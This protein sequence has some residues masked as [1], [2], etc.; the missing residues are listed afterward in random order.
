MLAN[1]FHGPQPQQNK[2]FVSRSVKLSLN[3]ISTFLPDCISIVRPQ[4]ALILVI[5][6]F[7]QKLTVSRDDSSYKKYGNKT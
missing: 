1:F 6:K 4:L 2:F 7:L 5:K 3:I